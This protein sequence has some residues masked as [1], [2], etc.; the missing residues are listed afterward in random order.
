MEN[1]DELV[2]NEIR[3]LTSKELKYLGDN[4]PEWMAIS[5]PFIISKW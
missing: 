4:Y 5:Y 3:K 1:F 2:N